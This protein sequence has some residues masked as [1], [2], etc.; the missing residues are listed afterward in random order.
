MVI[1]ELHHKGSILTEL[2]N[3]VSHAESLYRS[4]CSAPTDSPHVAHNMCPRSVPCKVSE[5][6][7]AWL[8]ASTP[9]DGRKADNVVTH[10][11]KGNALGIV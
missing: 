7:N 8:I 5:E 1:R 10:L 3:L 9:L 2:Q 11:P 4:F 6:Q